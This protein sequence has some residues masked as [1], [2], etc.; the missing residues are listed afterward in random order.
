[1]PALFSVELPTSD[2]APTWWWAGYQTS[3]DKFRHWF[4]TTGKSQVQAS[5]ALVIATIDGGVGKNG[6]QMAVNRHC[7][8]ATITTTNSCLRWVRLTMPFESVGSQG[9]TTANFN[10]EKFLKKQHRENETLKDAKWLNTFICE[11]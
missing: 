7:V 8:K 1:L 9:E 2:C 11:R 4:Q 5:A 6:Q 10:D 3:R